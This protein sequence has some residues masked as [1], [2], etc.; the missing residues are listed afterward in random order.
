MPRTTRPRVLNSD[1]S[2]RIVRAPSPRRLQSL[3]TDP[4]ASLPPLDPFVA[5]AESPRLRAAPSRPGLPPGRVGSERSLPRGRHLKN[6][7]AVGRV[8]LPTVTDYRELF[9]VI[10][11]RERAVAAVK[12]YLASMGFI[13]G[14]ARALPPE[15]LRKGRAKLARLLATL[16]V[17]TTQVVE[18]VELYVSNHCRVGELLPLPMGR[19]QML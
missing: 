17:H 18:L 7:A 2:P 15:V 11:A 16:R 13:R 14:S 4:A 8:P 5:K 1:G 6:R 12:A 19:Q 3:A 10:D 9:S